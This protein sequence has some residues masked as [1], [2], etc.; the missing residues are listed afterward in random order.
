MSK[1][2]FTNAMKLFK[3]CV[4]VGKE[5]SAGVWEIG[6]HLL[7]SLAFLARKP[8]YPKGERCLPQAVRALATDALL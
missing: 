5:I 3:P 4:C 6:N 2:Y 7:C 1:H 8:G